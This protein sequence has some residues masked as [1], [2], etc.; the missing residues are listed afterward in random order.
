MIERYVH[1]FTIFTSNPIQRET[2]YPDTPKKFVHE[3]T[4]NRASLLPA[5]QKL[6]AQGP[7]HQVRYHDQIPDRCHRD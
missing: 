2:K 7:A 6:L 3:I 4:L 5:H 1:D